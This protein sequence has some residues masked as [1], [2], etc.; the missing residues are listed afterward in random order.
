MINLNLQDSRPIYAQIIDGIKEQVLKGVLKE[1]DKIPS[2]RQ[3]AEML[4]ITPNTVS[5]AYQELEREKI[6]VSVRGRG[7]YVAKIPQ[8]R[9][10]EE[11]MQE[12]KK[13]LHQICVDWQYL[14]EPKENLV[15]IIQEIYQEFEHDREGEDTNVG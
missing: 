3:L 14:G 8:G 12:I 9:G 2:I 1:G 11:K 15:Q 6:I 10:G 13:L 7:N 4:S 5:K